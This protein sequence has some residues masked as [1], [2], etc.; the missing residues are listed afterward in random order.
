MSHMYRIK[1]TF[2]DLLKLF[3][4]MKLFRIKLCGQLWL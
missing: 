4:R 3:N 1:R 2:K